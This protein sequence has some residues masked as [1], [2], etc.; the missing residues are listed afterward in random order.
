MHRVIIGHVAQRNNDLAI[1]TLHPISV[2][3]VNFLDIRNVIED[4][5]R[6][7]AQVGFRSMQPCPF[8]QAY[9]KFNYMHERD[10]LIQTSPHQYGNDTISFIPH[11]RGSNHR[12]AMMTHEVWLMMIGLNLDLWTQPLVEKAVSSFG[13]LLIWEEDHFHM[14]RAI[15]KV[16][17]TSLEEVPWFFV[18]TDGV[19]YGSDSWSIQCEILQTTMLGARAQVEDFPP[20]DDGFDPNN[21]LYHGYGQMGQGPPPPPP[22]QPE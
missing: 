16:R 14:D 18:F 4:F 12:T 13:R 15:V 3:H 6:N 2:E 7:Q 17:V 21:F 19:N 20:G 8:G 10:L 5:L 11:N 9:V 22:E 1:A